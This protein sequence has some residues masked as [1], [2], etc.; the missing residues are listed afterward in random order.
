M[1]IDEKT[2]CYLIAI[3]N[4]LIRKGKPNNVCLPLLGTRTS[5][6][7]RGNRRTVEVSSAEVTLDGLRLLVYEQCGVH[8]KN[9]ALYQGGRQVEG[10]G[11]TTLR[12]ASRVN[13]AGCVVQLLC[14]EARVFKDMPIKVVNM[15]VVDDDEDV[16]GLL[17]GSKVGRGRERGFAGTAL[18][19]R[20][21][22][23]V[24]TPNE[25]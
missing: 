13:A 23:A 17:G 7:A 22:V 15:H 14:T 16:A 12:G 25:P 5:K 10:E 20:A 4:V 8:P 1:G 9:A 11:D 19:G 2:L 24:D 21:P 3:R 6:R 18:A